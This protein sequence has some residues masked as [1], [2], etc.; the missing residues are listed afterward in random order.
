MK[1]LA[2]SSFLDP[3]LKLRISQLGSCLS[4]RETIDELQDGAGDRRHKTVASEYHGRTHLGSHARSLA[5]TRTDVLVYE[6]DDLSNDVTISGPIN[7]DLFVSTTGTDADWIVKVID[8]YP[9]GEE[10][11]AYNPN[12]IEY[13][14]YQRL[15]RFDI[16]R[17]KF[18]NSFE[19]PEPFKPNEISDVSYRLQD[20]LH[21]FK[22]GHRVMIQIHSTWF[23][24]I[25][26]NPQK[27][28]DN[29]YKANEEDFIK[30]TITVYGSSVVEIGDLESMKA[31]VDV[32]K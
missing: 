6:T 27:Y 12:K 30:S 4:S 28:V 11:P 17:G 14:G 31:N 16:M 22:K 23:P 10:D 32:K 24:Y 7:V 29:I 5:A 25:D 1:I 13:G 15:I 19:K 2:V 8:V 9:D 3:F 20:I 18:R 26:R 21:T